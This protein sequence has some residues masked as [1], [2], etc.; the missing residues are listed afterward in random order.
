MAKKM[1]KLEKTL[2]IIF[3]F[4]F[5]ISTLVGILSEI[6]Y[7]FKNFS[8][9]LKLIFYSFIMNNPLGVIFITM[10]LMML[11]FFVIYWQ[12]RIR[13]ENK[14]FF[15]PFYIL[16]YVFAIIFAIAYYNAF[17]KF[18]YVSIMYICTS[19]IAFIFSVQSI[20]TMIINSNGDNDAFW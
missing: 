20:I 7:G 9:A 16:Y 1:V 18:N 11:I 8:F 17:Y 2:M 12:T 4:I 10:I 6:K 3:L 15:A 5:V 14:Y 19:I 13:K